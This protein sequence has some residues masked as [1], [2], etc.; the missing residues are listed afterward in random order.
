M[1]LKAAAAA[2]FCVALS[3]SLS[4]SGHGPVFGGAT[5]TLGKGGWQ[6]DQAW[7]GRSTQETMEQTLRSMISFGVTERV[8][9]STSVP[10]PL[11]TG[12]QPPMGR[13]TA[14]MADAP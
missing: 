6:F 7:M 4:A 10:I 11:T 12:S 14:T 5:P 8:Q 2:V 13:M 3:V 9:L 1:H